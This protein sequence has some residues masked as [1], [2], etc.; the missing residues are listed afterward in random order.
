MIDAP[1]VYAAYNKDKS[2]RRNSSSGG[3]FSVLAEHVLG[4]GGIV[5]GAGFDEG[6]RVCHQSV[7]SKEELPVL[8]GSKYV[9]S[10]IS[11]DLYKSVQK[12]LQ[13]GRLVFFT[14]TPCQVAGLRMFLRNRNYPNLLLADLVCHGVPSPKV[15]A[16]YLAWLE[17]KYGRKLDAFSFRDKKYS[18]ERFNVKAVLG[19]KEHVR[20]MNTDPYMYLFLSDP[21]RF[22]RKSCYQCQFAGTERIADITIAD[23][24]GFKGSPGMA[25]DDKG[26]SLLICN[27]RQGHQFWA[28]VR[29]RCAFEKRTM[30]E[31]LPWNPLLT[32][33]LPADEEAIQKFWDLYGASGF[34]G[35]A[36]RYYLPLRPKV[37]LMFR[38]YFPQ[39]FLWLAKVK[40]LIKR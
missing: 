31:A 1:E 2:I 19:G 14:G 25:H 24:W 20:V 33:P 15:F 8:R 13:S 29:D 40:R 34:A 16:D 3:V 5:Y 10:R 6:F 21:Q 35:V 37:K 36:E 22:L 27:T 11:A 39:L 30:A 9:Q 26:I 38:C 12:E 18:W 7:T 17:E 32:H 28:Q 23:F 4:Q